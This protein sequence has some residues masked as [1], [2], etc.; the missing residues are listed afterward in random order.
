MILIR[1]KAQ[2]PFL[3]CS[4]PFRQIQDIYPTSVVLIF[5]LPLL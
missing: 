4:T 2:V 1:I 3:I 5:A